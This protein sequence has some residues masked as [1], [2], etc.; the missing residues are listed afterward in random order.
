MNWA[1]ALVTA[2]AMPSPVSA[3]ICR[4]SAVR[5]LSTMSGGALGTE[6]LQR[7]DQEA[8]E[9]RKNLSI[10]LEAYYNEEAELLMN[11]PGENTRHSRRHRERDHEALARIETARHLI[12]NGSG[13]T[14]RERPIVGEYDAISFSAEAHTRRR[15]NF[16][17][18]PGPKLFSNQAAATGGRSRPEKLAILPL[19]LNGIGTGKA[20]IVYSIGSG[21]Q[22]DFELQVL[23]QTRCTVHTFDCTRGREMHDKFVRSTAARLQTPDLR[24]SY[25]CCAAHAGRSMI[26]SIRHHSKYHQVCI[27]RK[28]GSIGAM[29]R[30]Q[31]L[32]GIMAELGHEMVTLMRWDIE[33]FE[34][35]LFHDMLYE[36]SLRSRLPRVMQ[37]ELHYRALMHSR[38]QW[39][40]R[41]KTAGELALAGVQLYDAGFRALASDPNVGCEACYEYTILQTSCP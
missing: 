11:G 10:S 3:D 12:N 6:Q 14:L 21:G 34:Y 27:G 35:D 33:G 37:F 5:L 29:G 28:A 31:T 39:R 40:L 18:P 26:E 9:W 41:E 38:P 32:S 15:F 36:V 1:V 24:S 13:W 7:I 19:L 23:K 25:K 17:M 4:E 16:F 22:F 8:S 2:Y 30:F 20:C